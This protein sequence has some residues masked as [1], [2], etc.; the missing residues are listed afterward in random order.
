MKSTL[1]PKGLREEYH[2]Y[3]VRSVFVSS[4][5]RKSVFT[6]TKMIKWSSRV[7][8]GR[9]NEMLSG[10]I[11]EISN[12]YNL[13]PFSWFLLM[14]Y[15]FFLHSEWLCHTFIFHVNHNHRFFGPSAKYKLS[16]IFYIIIVCVVL[17]CVWLFVTL[18]TIAHQAPLSMGF[19]RQEYW[20]GLPCLPPGDLP[21]P[22]I[23]P[24]SLMSLALASGFF[25]T[26]TTWEALD[27]DKN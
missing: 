18:W 27:H 24:A 22:R 8:V 3:S 20:S 19:S 9:V 10:D 26:S 6:V 14:T 23:N 16:D 12:C 25:T 15:D 21:D 7:R 17:S 1:N 13:F 4:T 2:K 11:K 5:V